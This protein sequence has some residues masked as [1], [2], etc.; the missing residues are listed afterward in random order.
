MEERPVSKRTVFHTYEFALVICR[1]PETKKWL[2]VNESRG[3]GWWVPGGAVDAGETF[4]EAAIRETKEEAG[5][6]VNLRGILRVE[7]SLV[8]SDCARMRVIFLAEPVDHF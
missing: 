1:N 8:S 3:R 2:A 7:H 6:D 4:E 5:I